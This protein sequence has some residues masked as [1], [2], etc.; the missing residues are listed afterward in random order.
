MPD[1]KFDELEARIVRTIALVRTT[2]REKE[3]V[4]KELASARLLISKLESELDES[5]RDRALIKDKVESLLETLSELTEE[6]LV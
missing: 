6:S 4:E 5:R 3:V 1:V 2:R